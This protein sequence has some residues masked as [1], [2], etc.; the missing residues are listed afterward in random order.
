MILQFILLPLKDNIFYNLLILL[1]LFS[2][3][4]YACFKKFIFFS[5]LIIILLFLFG[6]YYTRTA[7]KKTDNL[8][9]IHFV[10]DSF[11]WF[12]KNNI[13]SDFFI[14]NEK[15]SSINL[16]K[17]IS[18]SKYIALYRSLGGCRYINSIYRNN[19]IDKKLLIDKNTVFKFLLVGFSS[20][21]NANNF[22]QNEKYKI[23]ILN[24]KY[25]R[26]LDLIYYEIKLY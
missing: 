6:S 4:L 5:E 9:S 8:E 10:R 18:G 26:D 14:F 3:L 24:Q 16:E 25:S 17:G 20:M 12:S 15:N 7:W 22:Y 1:S 2:A 21:D 13:R 11:D 19:I 23:T